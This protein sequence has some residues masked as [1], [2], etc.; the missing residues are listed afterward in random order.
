MPRPGERKSRS[1]VDP[2]RL[3]KRMLERFD[4][5]FS[6]VP[7]AKN[8]VVAAPDDGEN[9]PGGHAESSSSAKREKVLIPPPGENENNTVKRVQASEKFS[10]T[11]FKY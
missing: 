9:L 11:S 4:V 5:D 2:G 6:F 7:S 3:K 1:V 10:R 8:A